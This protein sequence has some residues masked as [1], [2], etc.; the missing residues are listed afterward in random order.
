M[1]TRFDSTADGRPINTDP[2]RFGT[3]DPM[4]PVSTAQTDEP[5][6]PTDARQ[7]TKG[8]PVLKVLLAGIVLAVI[9]WAGSEWWGQQTG[10]APE[11]T[12]TPP[13]GQIEPANPA[14][15]SNAN[16]APAPS[17]NP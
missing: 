17:S 16:P 9:A 1:S 5:M 12:A 10:P 14:P 8:T 13:A 2:P 4:D 11:Q 7:G 6:T 3:R 15:A